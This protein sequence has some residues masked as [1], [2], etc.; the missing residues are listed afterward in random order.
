MYDVVIVGS[1]PA[2]LSAA[3][4]AASE[5]LK[6]LVM[7]MNTDF[8]GQASTS[9]MI[10]NYAGFPD[11]VTGRDLTQRML[12]QTYKFDVE[13]MAPARVCGLER[14]EDRIRV[15]DDS[16]MYVD[17][18]SVVLAM[19]VQYR[20]LNVPSVAKYLG[21]GISYG[22]P[23]VSTKYRG[24]HFAVVGGANSAGQAAMHLSQY[25]DS[26]VRL[27]VRGDTIEDK[28][29]H[30]LIE[31]LEAADNVTIHYNSEITDVAGSDRLT[32]VYIKDKIYTEGFDMDNIFIL[33]G[34]IPLTNWMEGIIERDDHGF[35]L[36]GRDLKRSAVKEFENSCGRKPFDH[37]TS[38]RGVFASGDI[39]ANSV[40]RVASAVGEGAM[41]IPE[42]HK[43]V[44]IARDRERSEIL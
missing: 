30:Y 31:R 10:E 26:T 3:V 23:S 36:T 16:G 37:E 39:R 43:A 35:L 14:E 13:F 7:D 15:L 29:S 28:M 21:R 4:N 41:T 40:K 2:G 6:T 5:G 24:K 8:G 44:Q 42:V 38:M 18:R 33:I 32:Q 27:I 1:G 22:S 9:T 11:G 17:T 34:A 19:G 25:P 12:D 20:R